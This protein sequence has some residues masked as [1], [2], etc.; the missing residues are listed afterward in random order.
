[1]LETVLGNFI[2]LA[3]GLSVRPYRDTRPRILAGGAGLE[4]GIAGRKVEVVELRGVG[5]CLRTLPLVV[6][7]Q[8]PF[9]GGFLTC[10]GRLLVLFER[11]T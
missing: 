8:Y 7:G 10:A 9:V 4:D 3:I 6:F 2:L 1:L 5:V 11:L